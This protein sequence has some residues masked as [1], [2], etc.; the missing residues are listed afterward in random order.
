MFRK[1]SLLATSFLAIA[2]SATAI[3]S[4]QTVTP[5]AKVSINPQPLPPR[6]LQQSARIAA[7]SNMMGPGSRVMINPQPLPPK[8]Q[9]GAN[10]IR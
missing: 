7:G 10:G 4:A 5:G 9:N 1:S 8:Q 2:L 3:A 6:V